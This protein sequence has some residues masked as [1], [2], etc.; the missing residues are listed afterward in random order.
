MADTSHHRLPDPGTILTT[1]LADRRDRPMRPHWLELAEGPG[2]PQ[3]I[4]LDGREIIIGRADNA[5]IRLA[6]QRASRH[7]AVLTRRG[8][9]FSLRDN[10][11]RNGV[12]LNGVRVHSA[13]LRDGDVIQVADSLFIY[14]EG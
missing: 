13:T 11:S 5:Q 2:A 6:S 10:D 4:T 14:R 7:H 12:F 1:V 9:D 8:L 3:R